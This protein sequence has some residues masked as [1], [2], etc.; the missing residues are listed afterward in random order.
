MSVT[1]YAVL[2]KP[3]AGRSDKSYNA[4]GAVAAKAKQLGLDLTANEDGEVSSRELTD[5][6]VKQFCSAN[7]IHQGA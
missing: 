4:A 1:K 2:R 7:H 3:R 5:W 6:Y